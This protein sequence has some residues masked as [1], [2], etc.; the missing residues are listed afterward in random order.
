MRQRNILALRASIPKKISIL[1]VQSS[2][3]ECFLSLKG[4][5]EVA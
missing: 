1:K 3:R 2:N 4:V 5:F